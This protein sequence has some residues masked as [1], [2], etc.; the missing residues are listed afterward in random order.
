MLYRSY[1]LMKEE[2]EAWISEFKGQEEEYAF[3][4]LYTELDESDIF[5]EKKHRIA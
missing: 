5:Y 1:Y 4:K 3:L 2:L